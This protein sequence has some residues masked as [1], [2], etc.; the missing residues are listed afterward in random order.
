MSLI[1]DIGI[2]SLTPPLMLLDREALRLIAFSSDRRKLKP[3]EALFRKGSASY[4]GALVLS[5]AVALD[6]REDGAPARVAGRGALIGE[7]AL[8]A[9]VDHSAQSLAQ[10]ES[11]VMMISRQLFRRVLDEFPDQAG[12]IHAYYATELRALNG[13]TMAIARRLAAIS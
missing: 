7:L 8:I 10:E 2:M 11:E 5:G 3:K 12:A 1:D 9:A 6:P 4:G 13:E